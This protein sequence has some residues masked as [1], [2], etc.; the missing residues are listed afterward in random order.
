MNRAD[1]VYIPLCLYFNKVLMEDDLTFFEFTFHYVSILIM[2]TDLSGYVPCY[3][4]I[5][6]CLYF[7][8]LMMIASP[9]WSFVYIPLC[10]DFKES[11]RRNRFT[12]HYVSILMMIRLFLRL[13]RSPVYIPLCLYF[14]DNFRKYA[15]IEDCSLHSIMS[16]F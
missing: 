1:N 13:M 11:A 3:V 7:N 15:C 12:F 2:N 6:L 5:P 10:T 8:G 16:L 9:N 4:Y 14:N